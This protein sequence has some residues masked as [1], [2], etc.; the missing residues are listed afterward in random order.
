M[1]VKSQKQPKMADSSQKQPILT[2]K[3][4]KKLILSVKSKKKA[5]MADSSQKQPILTFK[6]QKKPILA[7]LANF[8]PILTHIALQILKV[9][10][11]NPK[12]NH[13]KPLISNN[14][15]KYT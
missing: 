5:K 14:I 3:S 8:Q 1:T 7:D 2:V 4:K 13:I 6:T 10:E 15:Y 11:T 9:L 12:P